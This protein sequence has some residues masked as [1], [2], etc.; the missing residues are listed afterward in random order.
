[1]TTASSAINTPELFSLIC[2]Y[3][4]VPTC[5][6]LLRVSKSHFSAA[7]SFVWKNLESPFHLLQLIPNIVVDS[8]AGDSIGGKFEI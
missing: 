8:R 2:S 1:M 7:A 6:T 3:A 4:D 5:V